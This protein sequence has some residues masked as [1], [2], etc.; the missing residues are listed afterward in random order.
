M[1]D[2]RLLMVDRIDKLTEALLTL[3]AVEVA[4]RENLLPDQAANP[5][6]TCCVPA[7]RNATRTRTLASTCEQ[8]SCA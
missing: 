2:P 1:P 3:A 5:R 8:L 4:L 7:P 6:L